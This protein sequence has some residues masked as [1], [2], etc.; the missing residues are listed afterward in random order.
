M[1]V[2]SLTQPAFDVLVAFM[3][4]DAHPAAATIATD[5]PPASVAVPSRI[6]RV[7]GLLRRLIDYGRQLAVTVQQRAAAPDFVLFARPFGTA[8]LAVILARITAGLRR[9]AALEA[10]LSRRAASGRDLTPSPAPSPRSSPAEQVARPDAR[11]EP[12]HARRTEDPHLAQLPTELEIAAELRRR[13]IGAVI[14]DICRDFGI[15]PGRLDAA[16]WRELSHAIITYGGSLAG[17]LDTLHRRLFAAGP[18]D[19]ADLA[20]PALPPRSAAPATGPP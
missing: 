4:V 14:A 1:G 9:A 8:D 3:P 16:L 17:F 12:R 19:R 15:A 2:F 6:G 10:A 7:L 13:P 20:Q 18:G 11:P 5:P